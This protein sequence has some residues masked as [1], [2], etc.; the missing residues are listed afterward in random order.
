MKK[1]KNIWLGVLIIIII[2]TGI[3]WIQNSKTLI[4]NQDMK[5]TNKNLLGFKELTSQELSNMLSQKDFTLIDVHIPEQVHIPETDY[6]IP[7]NNI[8]AFVSTFPDKNSKIVLYCRSGGMS[9]AVAEA[10][11][12][13]GYTNIFNLTNGMNEWLNESRE[14]IPKGSL[15]KKF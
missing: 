12:K 9:K 7:Y 14:T 8:K 4:K 13:R 6:M 15:F 5:I 1:K 10:L 2:V 3:Y 11:V